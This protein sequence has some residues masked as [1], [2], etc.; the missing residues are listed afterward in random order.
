MLLLQQTFGKVKSKKK[1]LELVF[2]ERDFKLVKSYNNVA[3]LYD[4]KFENK[5]IKLIDTYHF[6]SH[7]L[8]INSDKAL[9]YD[10]V[11]NLIV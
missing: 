11:S 8:T 9:F 4:F 7:F 1:Y 2:P 3:N 10:P 5:K 6:S